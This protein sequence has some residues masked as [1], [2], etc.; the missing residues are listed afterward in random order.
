MA[1]SG[2]LICNECGK[3]YKVAAYLEQHMD[4]HHS[5]SLGAT[6]FANDE[7]P[8]T[9]EDELEE[10]V[11]YENAGN[12]VAWVASSTEYNVYTSQSSRIYPFSSDKVYNLAKW[13]V[14]NDIPVTAVDELLKGGTNFGLEATLLREIPSSYVVREKV[15]M[16][17][18]S[19]PDWHSQP[20]TYRWTDGPQSEPLAYY[21]RD[22]LACIKWFLRQNHFKKHLH[23]A[24]RRNYVS[25]NRIYSD[26]YTAEWWWKKQVSRA[27]MYL[28]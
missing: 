24:P 17:H 12:P 5:E 9:S 27:N 10:F 22:T 18:N 20:C 23:Y 8:V 26:L 3:R 7:E 1:N 16:M 11:E 4:K 14:L 15:A 28:H 25:G 21:K 13:L 2:R 19:L 6:I